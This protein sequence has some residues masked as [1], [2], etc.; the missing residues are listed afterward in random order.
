MTHTPRHRIDALIAATSRQPIAGLLTALAYL[1]VG[2]AV[3]GL[4]FTIISLLA[5][6]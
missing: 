1:M 3:R 4:V 5:H 2:M 6:L